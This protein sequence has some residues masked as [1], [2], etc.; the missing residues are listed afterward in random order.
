MDNLEN[1]I[2][3]NLSGDEIHKLK[4]TGVQEAWH[5]NGQ[6]CSRTHY[7][8]GKLDG[9]YESWYDNGQQCELA[10]YK[11]GKLDGVHLGWQPNGKVS[12]LCNYK[13]GLL[14]GEYFNYDSDGDLRY[15]T[16]CRKGYD[17]ASASPLTGEYE[18]WDNSLS[19]QSMAVFYVDRFGRVDQDLRLQDIAEQEI[20]PLLLESEIRSRKLTGVQEA[21]YDGGQISHLKYY[22]DGLPERKYSWHPN[23][24]LD[25]R[26]TYKAGKLDGVSLSYYDNGQLC[27]RTHYKRGKHD[28]LYESWYDNGQ[29]QWRG[30][31]KDDKLEGLFEHW[32]PN[33]EL[34]SRISHQAGVR[35]GLCEIWH[36]N[37]QLKERTTCKAGKL[38]G[39]SEK[40]YPNGQLYERCTYKRGKL[41]GLYESWHENGQLGDKS[42]FKDG[43]LCDQQPK[44][45]IPTSPVQEQAQAILDARGGDVKSSQKQEQEAQVNKSSLKI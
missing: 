11:R 32:S 37:G 35:D 16:H 31:Y 27:S 13:N 18:I 45:T 17:S 42:V 30:S 33:G 21:Y 15:H 39:V 29:L 23:G 44:I 14:H 34:K 26:A 40:W 38:E 10:N 24:Q 2:A 43:R 41:D 4:L 12:E 1:F 8:R 6:L 19:P 20:D 22:I 36:D 7:Q 9:L 25:E 28:G 5:E 3:P